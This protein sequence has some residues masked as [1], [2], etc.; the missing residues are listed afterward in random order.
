[1]NYDKIEL[2]YKI[3]EFK[4][5]RNQSLLPTLKINGGEI[6][7]FIDD[8][9]LIKT[10]KKDGEHF[11]FT[12]R[13]ESPA[14]AGFLGVIVLHGNGFIRWLVPQPIKEG[15]SFD[16]VEADN[17]GMIKYKEYHF[18]KEQYTSALLDGF[19]QRSE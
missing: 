4:E 1:M 18:N 9:V 12:H 5:T 8:Y 10:L 19:K 7:S 6:K 15:D 2:N 13:P 3:A 11:L 14:C 16:D 17:E